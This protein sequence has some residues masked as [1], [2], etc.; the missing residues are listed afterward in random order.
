MATQTLSVTFNGFADVARLAG[1]SAVEW[2]SRSMTAY[3]VWYDGP[4]SRF[5]FDAG[6]SGTNWTLKY[7]SVASE[8]NRFFLKDLDFGSG[9]EIRFLELG[10]NSDVDLIS[11]NIRYIRG[12]DGDKH[13]IALGNNMTKAVQSIHLLAEENIVTTGNTRVSSITT[14]LGGSD[15]ARAVGDTIVIGR[16]GAGTVSTNAG[17][18]SVTTTRAWVEAI[19]TG[20]NDDTVTI[21]SGEVGTVRTGNGDD[22]VD[23]I[24]GAVEFI[25]TGAGNDLV[26]LGTN[27]GGTLVRM[28]AGDDTLKVAQMDTSDTVHIQAGSGADTIDFSKFTKGVTFTLNS[29]GIFQNVTNP[30]ETTSGQGWF[31]EVSLDNIIG[32]NKSDTLTGDFAANVLTGRGGKDVIKGG[33][34]DDKLYGG[35]NNDRLFGEDGKDVLIG[36]TGRDVLVGGKGNDSLR[37]N[38]GADVFVFGKASGTDRVVDFADGSDIL[39]ISDHSGGLAGLTIAALGDDLTIVHDGGVIVLVGEAGTKLTQADFDFV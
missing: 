29:G 30:G 10:Y 22:K 4:K 21:G 16:G 5:V 6:L 13:E 12:W 11:T 28:G 24:V 17:K 23:A 31:S 35:G 2:Y 36:G 19:A 38:G 34:G 32:T 18:D 9:R 27:A 39:R 1:Q 14:G 33:A 3:N 20:D 37:G 25:S 8:D 7:L 26:K 15:A